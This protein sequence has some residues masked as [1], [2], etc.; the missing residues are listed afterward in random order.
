MWGHQVN[1]HALTLSLTKEPSSLS[2]PVT[3]IPLIFAPHAVFILQSKRKLIC[4][5]C[6]SDTLELPA[7]N[8]NSRVTSWVYKAHCPGSHSVGLVF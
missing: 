4:C 2:T 3:V 1:R 8:V 7:A 6:A 5:A